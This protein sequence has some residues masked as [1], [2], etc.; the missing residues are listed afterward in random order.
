MFSHCFTPNSVPATPSV[1]AEIKTHETR[2]HFSK[3]QLSR[4]GEPVQFVVSIAR[5]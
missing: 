1:A 4:F 2:L 5:S 3:L